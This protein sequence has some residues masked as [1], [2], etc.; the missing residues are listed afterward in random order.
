MRLSLLSLPN[1]LGA[2]PE[3]PEP[4]WLP[5]K[6]V[7]LLDCGIADAAGAGTKPEAGVVSRPSATGPALELAG[8]SAVGNTAPLG[9]STT[10]GLLGCTAC[11]V[12]LA[13]LKLA[14]LA[15]Q[16]TGALSQVVSFV[17][18]GAPEK[19]DFGCPEV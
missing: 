6:S 5:N 1:M 7:L 2:T 16:S 19:C 12:T 4:R 14:G 3:P 9:P 17:P 11:D 10:L 13:S 15:G 18:W 8:T